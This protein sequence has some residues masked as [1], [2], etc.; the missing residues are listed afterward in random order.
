MNSR[1][2]QGGELLR[3]WSGAAVGISRGKELEG[4]EQA[5]NRHPH[6]VPCERTARAFTA[7]V[8]PRY[9]RERCMRGG[10]EEALGFELG[11]FWV[12]RGIVQDRPERYTV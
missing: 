12:G 8:A 9:F 11:R 1:S 3:R 10:I 5:R 7:A 6:R 2:K 4:G